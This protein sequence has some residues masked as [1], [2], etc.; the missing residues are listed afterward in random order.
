MKMTFVKLIVMIATIL[1]TTVI[2]SAADKGKFKIEGLYLEGC[3][4]GIPCGCDFMG[5]SKGCEGVGLVQVSSGTYEGVDLAGGKIALAL[6]PGSWVRVFTDGKDAEQQM[7]LQNFAK[8]A[9]ASMGKV[10]SVKSAK[11]EIT[12]SDG[13]YKLA[14]NDGRTMK[15]S[16]KPVLGGDKKTPIMFSNAK[17]PLTSMFLQARSVSGS[18]NDGDRAFT[19]K[20]SNAY[21][22]NK[23]MANGK[24]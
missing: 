5:P 7:A 24:L 2:A 10:E 12:G 21:F 14:V 1:L 9:F 23:M 17:H 15:L 11:V 20:G 22:N 13:S 4:C 6:V 18:F 19:L 8:K 3:S 16:T